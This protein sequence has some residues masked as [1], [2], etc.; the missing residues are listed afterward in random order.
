M[1]MVYFFRI[2]STVAEGM[3]DEI[4]APK[5]FHGVSEFPNLEREN[6]KVKCVTEPRQDIQE[7]RKNERTT[8]QRIIHFVFRSHLFLTVTYNKSNF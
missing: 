1:A 2:I 7:P 8:E 6:K 3:R 5:F 4:T